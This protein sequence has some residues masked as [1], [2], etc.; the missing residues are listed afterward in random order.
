MPCTRQTYAQ[1]LTPQVMP[2]TLPG[3]I[4]EHRAGSKVLNTTILWTLLTATCTVDSY[5]AAYWHLH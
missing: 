3:A 1:S 4:P 5:P 2:Q